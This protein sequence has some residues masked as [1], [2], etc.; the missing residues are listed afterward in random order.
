MRGRR[1]R[2]G[3]RTHVVYAGESLWSIARDLLGPD[4]SNAAVAH[5]VEPALAT[6]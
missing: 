4:A 2:R 5:H 6:Q 1:A 3:D